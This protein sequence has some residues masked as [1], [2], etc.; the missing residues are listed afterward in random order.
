[1]RLSEIQ[2]IS[3]IYKDYKIVLALIMLLETIENHAK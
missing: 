2:H 1:M 3:D